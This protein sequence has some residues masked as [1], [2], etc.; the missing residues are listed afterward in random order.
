MNQEDPVSERHE[1]YYDYTDYGEND[2]R[3]LR[4]VFKFGDKS[5]D[6][7]WALGTEK[8]ASVEFFND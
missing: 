4:Y 3:Q 2:A 7:M 5:V 6:V 8:L 1:V